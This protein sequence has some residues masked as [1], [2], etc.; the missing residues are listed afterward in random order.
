M[1]R[2]RTRDGK[3]IS[4]QQVSKTYHRAGTTVTAVDQVSLEVAQG[5]IFGVIGQSG[6]GKSTLLRLINLL[7]RPDAGSVFVDGQD[8]TALNDREL[9]LARRGIGMVFQHF[10]LLA[11]RTVAGNVELGLEIR[12][13]PAAERRKRTAEILNLVGLSS[14]A[15]AYP[16]ELSGGQKQRV[17]IARALAGKPQVLLLDEATSALDP[18]TTR[19]ILELIKS[20]NRELGLTVLLITHEMNVIKSICDSAAFIEDGRVVESGKVVSLISMPG[21][22]LAK[23]LFPLGEFPASEDNTVID[24]TFSG[25]SADSSVISQLARKYNLDVSILGAAIETI[26]GN[27]AGRTRLQIP[28]TPA[29]NSDVIDDLRS[30]GLLVEIASSTP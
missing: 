21:S 14:K 4:V 22:K 16:V 11:G 9:K 1:W 7:E 24:I 2:E 26:D 3:V 19:S 23:E 6:A 30:Q 29:K 20:L 8:L 18:E 12:N 27:Q 5:E 10:N 25:G 13:V 15:D 28:G 17:G